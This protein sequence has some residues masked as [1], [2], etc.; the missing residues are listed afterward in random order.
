MTPAPTSPW[1]LRGMNSAPKPRLRLFCFPHGGA[2]PSVFRGWQA[3]AGGDVEVVAV[4]LP[5]RERRI[6][7]PLSCSISELR[8]RLVEPITEC[9]GALPYAFLGHS[10]GALIAYELCHEFRNTLNPPAALAVTGAAAAHLPRTVPDVH[11]LPDEQFRTHISMLNGTPKE[12]LDDEAW[13]DLLIPVLR[14]DF[15]A[16]ETYTH[17]DDR[18]LLDLPLLALGGFADP[19]AP[20]EAVE[21]W[22]DLS[23]GK[24]L[25]RILEGDHFFLFSHIAEVIGMVGDAVLDGAR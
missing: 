19:L 7:E 20:P 12:L 24:V 2:G 10:M 25:T 1:F 16:C 4:Q 18:A 22:A 5:G 9:A 17:S 21:R 3:I 13:V 23:A 8:D 11:Q 15:E 6:A 14:A